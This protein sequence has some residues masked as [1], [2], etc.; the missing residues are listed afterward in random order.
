MAFIDARRQPVPTDADVCIVGLGA[1]GTALATRL[2]ARGVDVFV[3][4]SGAHA[5][6]G[7]TQSLYAMAQTGVRYYDMTSCRLRFVGGTTNH[8]GGYCRENDPIDYRGRRELGVPAWPFDEAHIRP[9]VVEAAGWLGLTEAGFDPAHQVAQR[10]LPA[11]TLI[12]RRSPLLS[13]KVFQIAQNRRLRATHIPP[14]AGHDRVRVV[15]HANVV[16]LQLAG[17]GTRRRLSHVVVRTLDGGEFRVRSRRFVLAAHAVE[18]ARLLLASDDVDRAGIGNAH[19]HVGRYF[20]EH[21]H[22]F[23]GL[24]VPTRSFPNFYSADVMKRLHL[25][26]N[27]GLTEAALREHG[28]LQYYC[29]FNPVYHL[30]RTADALRGLKRGF[31]RP[32]DLD[33]IRHLGTLVSNVPDSLRY[34]RSRVAPDSAAPIFYRLEHRIEQSPNPDSR[35]TLA[36]DRDSVGVRRA[37]LH[38]ALSDLDL[39]TFRRGQQ[40]VV[41]ELTRLG[42]GRFD[43]PEITRE[44]IEA[45]AAG[46][47]HHIGTTRMAT[48]PRDGVVDADG[49]VHGVDNL[50]VA[51][52]GVF[53]TAGYSGPTMMII[54]LAIRLAEHLAAA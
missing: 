27:L 23:S 15:T 8:W 1:A 21:P 45:D 41:G 35:I 28:I 30:H 10:G 20:M 53:P 18:N 22:L 34:A 37:V 25:N 39:A 48:N 17:D 52:S 24:M 36:D 38:W 49:K 9:Y 13:T 42:M 29:R 6:E 5:V 51:G 7:A 46:H 11:D 3:V 50:Y 31:W 14:L 12:E 16:H 26:A 47:Y 19:G 44:R 54:A 4:E 40:I 33:A 2:A 32:A 43:A